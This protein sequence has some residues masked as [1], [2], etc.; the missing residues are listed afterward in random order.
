MNATIHQ[1]RPVLPVGHYLRL[2]H[3]GYKQLEVLHA[4]GRLAID[5]VVVDAAHI[6]E[7]K[8]LLDSL[9]ESNVEII[10]D[11]KVAELSTPGGFMTSARKLPWAHPERPYFVDDFDRVRISDM[12]ERIADFSI[13]HQVDAVLGATRLLDG[14]QD[15]W[16]HVDI[17]L[18]EAFRGALDTQGAKEIATDYPLLINY[19]TLLDGAAR[20]SLISLL[21]G[22]PFEFL[23]LRIANFGSDKS[24]SGLRKYINA[25]RDFHDIGK[26]I[27]ADGVGGLP[28]LSMVAF[29]GT[30]GICHGVAEK[31]RFYPNYWRKPQNQSGGGSGAKRIYFSGLD[32]Y[33]S[34]EQARSYGQKWCFDT[35]I[36][37]RPD[38]SQLPRHRL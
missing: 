17:E 13:E 28:A 25:A 35:W 29:G 2:G 1:L 10:L 14:P 15:K 26:P 36:K 27:I 19:Q 34:E 32:A 3:T 12:A 38:R 31:E 16:M 24:A 37:R 21:A 8:E 23:W 18:C 11:P 5:R 7:Q 30:G 20:K 33:L 4:S 6:V 22:L 9:R